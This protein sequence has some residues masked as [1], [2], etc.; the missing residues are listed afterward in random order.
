[1]RAS[2][3]PIADQVLAL[4]H[5]AVKINVPR[6]AYLPL[7]MVGRPSSLSVPFIV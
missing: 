3:W 1:M 4:F 7:E 6:S 2:I 5:V